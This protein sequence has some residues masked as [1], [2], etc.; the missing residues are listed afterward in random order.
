MLDSNLVR[1][2]PTLDA[3]GGEHA[4][5]AAFLSVEPA[6]V[7]VE[8]DE[9]LAVSER[10][11]SAFTGSH[12]PVPVLE[13][14]PRHVE[15]A[16]KAVPGRQTA[17]GRDRSRLWGPLRQWRRPATECCERRRVV[18]APIHEGAMNEI[19]GE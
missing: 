8:R 7:G 18:G 10:T 6:G 12:C 5:A 16:A 13:I 3:D 15:G 4:W 1:S 14:R 9:E 2:L 11:W 19:T 17:R